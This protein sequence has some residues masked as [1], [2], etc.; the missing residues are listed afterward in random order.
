IKSLIPK[1]LKVII[2]YPGIV[3]GP[4]DFNVFGRM[5]YDVMRGKILPLGVCPGEGGS[6]T[7]LS[8]VYDL[9]NAF[10]SVVN[11]EDLFGEDFIL[12][13]ENVKFRE[14]LDLIAEI[15]RDKKAKKLPF[16]VTI[17][18]AWLLE[19]KAFFNKKVPYLTR[20]TLRAIRYHRAYSSKKAIEKLNYK[21]TPLREGLEKTIKWYKE[22]NEKEKS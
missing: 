8:Y 19:V 18:Y 11:R 20:P 9:S 14:Y 21:I 15:G 2:F 10:V 1:G 4:R 17:V 12:G 6:M 5:L 7:C 22:F 16:W 3:Y 13:G